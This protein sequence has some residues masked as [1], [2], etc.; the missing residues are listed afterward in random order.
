M[1]VRAGEGDFADITKDEVGRFSDSKILY[2]IQQKIT[3]LI[4]ARDRAIS[5]L[6]R[7]FHDIY[8]IIPEKKLKETLFLMNETEL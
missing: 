3:P 5:V 2:K 1:K 4:T 8:N 6:E 7:S